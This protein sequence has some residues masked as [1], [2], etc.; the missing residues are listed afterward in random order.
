MLGKAMLLSALKRKESRGAHY[1]EDYPQMDDN[2]RKS[3]VASF[4]ED[5]RISFADI[6]GG[7]CL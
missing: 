7:E 4:Y 1:R 5:I 2:Y 3:T 6:D